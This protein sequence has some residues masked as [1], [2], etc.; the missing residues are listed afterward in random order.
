MIPRIVFSDVD[1][2]LLNSDHRM[3]PGSLYAVRELEKLGIPFVIISGR[4]PS[5]IRPILRENGFS[6]PMICYSGA[7]TLDRDG[8][9]LSSEGFDV[10]TAVSLIDFIENGKFDCSWNIYSGD[11][12]IVKDRTD[13][14]V[15]NEEAEVNAI[16]MEGGTGSLPAGAKVGKIL[17]ICAPGAIGGLEAAIREAFPR[18]SVARSSDILLEIMAGG[19]TKSTAVKELCRRWD[20]PLEYTAAFGDHFNDAE[21]LGTV[22]MPFL[23]ENAPDELKAMGFTLTAGNDDEGIYKALI[24]NGII[25]C[26]ESISTAPRPGETSE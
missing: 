4:S 20:I 1:G 8:T 10:D 18:L 9:V 22:A 11:T 3:L 15:L 16:S 12:W 25:P 26:C 19:V 24:A 21:M 2:T 14:R 7:L 23:M 6:C 13:P 5:G 17:C